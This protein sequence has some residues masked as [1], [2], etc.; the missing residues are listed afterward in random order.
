MLAQRSQNSPSRGRS[1]WAPQRCRVPA[2]LPADVRDVQGF[3]PMMP[4]SNK[5]APNAP[6]NP[7]CVGTTRRSSPAARRTAPRA[8]RSPGRPGGGAA[9]SA[10]SHW[11]AY[12]IGPSLAEGEVTNISGK[13]SGA[14]TQGAIIR[15]RLPGRFPP[16][17]F[18]FL[19]AI[20]PKDGPARAARALGDSQGRAGLVGFS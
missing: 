13:L 17:P 12:G 3:G 15:P 2:A 6:A 11:V 8:S 10:F 18:T 9:V 5:N 1:L 7:N 16:P 20:C 14:R 19:S 4:R